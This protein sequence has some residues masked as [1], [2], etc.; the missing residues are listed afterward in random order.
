MSHPKNSA[1]VVNVSIFLGAV[2]PV[3]IN[4]LGEDVCFEF[5]LH[6]L[7]YPCSCLIGLTPFAKSAKNRAPTPWL[8]H[9]EIRREGGQPRSIPLKYSHSRTLRLYGLNV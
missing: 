8:S 6:D 3:R 7:P 5:L 9:R 2:G 4:G 1:G